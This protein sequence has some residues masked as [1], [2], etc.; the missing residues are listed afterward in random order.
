MAPCQTS[1]STEAMAISSAAVFCLAFLSS[2]MANLVRR[3]TAEA[4]RAPGRGCE[5]SR[6]FFE[7]LKNMVGCSGIEA[8]TIPDARRSVR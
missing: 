5:A 1:F 4:V 7:E 6:L 8:E 3:L 2:V